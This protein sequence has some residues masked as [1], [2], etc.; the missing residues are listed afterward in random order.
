MVGNASESRPQGEGY[1]PMITLDDG[2]TRRFIC[3]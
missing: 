2:K 3:S 1:G